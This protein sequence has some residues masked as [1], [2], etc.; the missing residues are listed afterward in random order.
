MPKVVIDLKKVNG[1]YG[2]HH[3]AQLV[4]ASPIF[5]LTKFNFPYAP[6]EI[7]YSDLAHGWEEYKRPGDFSILDS[8]GPKNLKVQMDFRYADPKSSGNASIEDDLNRLRLIGLD[9][10]PV[11]FVNLDTYLSSPIFPSFIAEAFG[12]RLVLFRIAELSIV[13]KRRNQQN[14]AT[15]AD[16]SLSLI[17]DRNPLIADVALPAISYQDAPQ[18]AGVASP[19]GTSASPQDSFTTIS[20]LEARV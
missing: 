8:T 13:V 19:G 3:G 15:Q 14:K 12:V 16:I 4:M 20:P 11:Y 6:V 1:R 2:Y 18:R 17:E 5:G 9:G 7:S 10:S